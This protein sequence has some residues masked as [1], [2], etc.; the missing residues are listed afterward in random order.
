MKLLAAA[1][2][3]IIA[4]PVSAAELTSEY[5]RNDLSKTVWSSTKQRQARA[6]GPMS[7]ARV[8]QGILIRSAIRMAARR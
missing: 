6:T 4:V 7:S 1:I 2:F 3:A 8:L 5:T